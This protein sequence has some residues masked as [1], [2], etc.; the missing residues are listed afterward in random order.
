M[1]INNLYDNLYHLTR[2]VTG[3]IIDAKGRVFVSNWFMIYDGIPQYELKK[4][5]YIKPIK[6]DIILLN[7]KEIS[8]QEIYNIIKGKKILRQDYEFDFDGKGAM[9]YKIKGGLTIICPHAWL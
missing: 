5:G 4:F 3:I 9:L 6:Y 1:G 2:K 7:K 8:E